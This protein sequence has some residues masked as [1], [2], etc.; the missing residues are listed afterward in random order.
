MFGLRR[1]VTDQG[2]QPLALAS[3][4]AVAATIVGTTGRVSGVVLGVPV[5]AVAIV[6]IARSKWRLGDA[7]IF[8]ILAG[9][10]TGAAY[11]LDAI[12]HPDTGS[13]GDQAAAA[14]IA[15]GIGLWSLAVAFLREL[16]RTVRVLLIGASVL[17]LVTWHL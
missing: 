9:L 6:V 5:A 15:F 7:G 14:E 11:V 17:L 16:P 8:V 4:A 3:A 1:H 10:G 13:Y 2:L 12:L